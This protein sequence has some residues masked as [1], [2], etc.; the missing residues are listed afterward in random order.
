[1][2]LQNVILLFD[3]FCIYILSDRRDKYLLMAM[4]DSLKHERIFYF[5]AILKGLQ[6]EQ[7]NT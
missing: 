6:T 5:S 4:S 1:M 2:S 3:M 7:V